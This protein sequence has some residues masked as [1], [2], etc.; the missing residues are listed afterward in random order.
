[1]RLNESGTPTNIDVHSVSAS[2][3]I[4]RNILNRLREGILLD[5]FFVCLNEL[6][7]GMNDYPEWFLPSGRIRYRE[8]E[9]ECAIRNMIE[10]GLDFHN[11]AEL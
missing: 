4:I 6:R 3:T 10:S 1:M 11:M 2:I 9:I 7:S 8:T 5:G